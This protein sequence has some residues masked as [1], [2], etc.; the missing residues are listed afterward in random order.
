MKYNKTSKHIKLHDILYISS[1]LSDT[2]YADAIVHVADVK[3]L[4]KRK[5]ISDCVSNSFKLLTFTVE[6]QEN[7]N[8][9]L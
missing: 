5:S 4:K 8:D 1:A 3:G 6:S 9:H 7:K 2:Y